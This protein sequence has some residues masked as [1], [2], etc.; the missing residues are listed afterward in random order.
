MMIN[1]TLKE[2]LDRIVV[3][4]LDD[5]LIYTDGDLEQ[6]IKDV[7]QVLTK[8]QERNLK[9]NP[10]KCEFHVKN[11]EFLGFI[12]R[13]DGIRIDSAKITSIKDWP[14]PKNL[15]EVQSFLRLANYNRK[16]IA[17]YS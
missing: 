1:D 11:T 2:Y 15:K 12:I 7:Q 16:F 14:T 3:A 4:Y 8:L 13:V 6:H 9:A 5:I 10:K 17:G